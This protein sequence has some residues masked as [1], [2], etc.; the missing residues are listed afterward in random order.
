MWCN[1]R[2][3]GIQWNFVEVLVVVVLAYDKYHVY[4]SY[5]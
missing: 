1:L 2:G 4:A 5:R 3:G